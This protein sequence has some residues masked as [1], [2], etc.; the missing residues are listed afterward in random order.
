[1]NIRLQS[2]TKNRFLVSTVAFGLLLAAVITLIVFPAL[3]EI[4]LISQQVYEERIRLE[5]LYVRGQLQKIVREKYATIEHSI[6]FL[7]TILLKENQELEYI[8]ALERVAE[9]TGVELGIAIGD[10]KRIPEQTYS[11]LPF[12]FSVSGNWTSILRWVEEVESLP[13]YTNIREISI[14]VREEAGGQGRS[15]AVSI[16]ADTYWLIP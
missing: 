15:A 5:K 14:S 1:M 2:Y 9:S 7:N 3:R 11:T 13:Y 4:R 10:P 12:T 16:G 8:T 6:G